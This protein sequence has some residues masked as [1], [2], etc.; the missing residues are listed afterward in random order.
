MNA[1]HDRQAD[2]QTDRQAD[3]RTDGRAGNHHG[4]ILQAPSSLDDDDDL[5]TSSQRQSASQNLGHKLNQ[6]K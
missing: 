2:R 3:R 5:P 4:R 6:L 1:K